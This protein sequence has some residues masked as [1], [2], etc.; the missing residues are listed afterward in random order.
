MQHLKDKAKSGIYWSIFDSFFL[1][2]LLFVVQLILA[3]KLGPSVFG[4]M[5]MIT[6]IINL[7]SLIIDS[8]LGASLIRT[9]DADE[10]DYNTVFYT[11]LL[12][13]ILLYGIFY[14]LAPLFALFY[15]EPQLIAIIRIYS[16]G[17]IISSMNLVQLAQLNKKMAFKKIA[18]F[19]I[20]G[21]IAGIVIG[22]LMCYNGYGIWS[23]VYLN[24]GTQSVST[25]IYYSFSKWRPRM[26]FSKTKFKHHLNFGFKLVCSGILDIFFKNIYFVIIGR[27]FPV[28]MLGYYERANTYNQYPVS[29]LSGIISTVS[30]PLLASIKNDSERVAEVYRLILKSS[31]FVTAPVMVCLAALAP[32]LFSFVLGT[33]WMPAVPF[34]QIICISSIL[35][36]LQVFNVNILKVYGQSGLFLKLEIIKKV[37]LLVTVVVTYPFGIYAFVGSS[38]INAIIGYLLNSHYCGKF[39]N[40]KTKEQIMDL[41]PT[42]ICCAVLFVSIELFKNLTFHFSAGSSI[43]ASIMIGI[44][45][46]IL[47]HH[48]S[49]SSIYQ[50]L[51][52]SYVS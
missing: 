44:V 41:M 42:L 9:E 31:F 38:I 47:A 27:F 48:I 7:G 25:L 50:Y 29:T 40:Y 17:F 46:Y 6:I 43:I 32:E 26:L 19:N 5:G 12:F 33:Q 8:G 37:F 11:N 39:I 3:K 1:K 51:L 20:A 35:Y 18:L 13:A 21:T 45:V 15:Q 30:Y 34:F 28:K 52:K 14:L 23:L 49:K 24:L 2:G 22:L 10:G 16:L 4:M 36:P